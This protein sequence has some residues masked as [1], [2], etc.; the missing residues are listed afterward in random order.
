MDRDFDGEDRTLARIGPDADLVTQQI[1]QAL[2]DGKAKAKAMAPFPRGVIDLMV[3]LE[4]R[5]KFPGGDADPGIPDVDAEICS[6][7]SATE[8]HRAALGVLHRVRKQV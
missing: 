6:A 5:L 4:D 1:S 8:Q 2:N 7:P 3:F